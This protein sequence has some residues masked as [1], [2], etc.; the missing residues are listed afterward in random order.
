MPQWYTAGQQHGAA[1]AAQ[2]STIKFL[3]GQ[4]LLHSWTGGCCYLHALRSMS[5]AER[6]FC[7]NQPVNQ[8]NL[9]LLM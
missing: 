3:C 4:V 2:H 8:W 7:M 6:R 9:I 1:E 5:A